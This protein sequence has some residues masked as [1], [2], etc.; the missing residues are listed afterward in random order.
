MYCQRVV[1]NDVSGC[2]RRALAEA[3]QVVRDWRE[4]VEGKTLTDREAALFEMTDE[5]LIQLF[6]RKYSSL[7]CCAGM[8]S[9]D[10]R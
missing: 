9:G 2:E 4:E 7:L 6:L 5:E 1:I 10:R 8:I 3:S